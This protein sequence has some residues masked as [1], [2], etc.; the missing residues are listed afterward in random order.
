MD[1]VYEVVLTQK[2][3]LILPAASASDALQSAIQQVSANQPFTPTAW[4]VKEKEQ[5]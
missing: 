5:E 4:T 1:P 2:I 3:K